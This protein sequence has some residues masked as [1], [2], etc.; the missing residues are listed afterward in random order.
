MRL[1]LVCLAVLVIALSSCGPV[2]YRAA[3]SVV[4][5]VPAYQRFVPPVF[6]EYGHIIGANPNG[7]PVL[8]LWDSGLMQLSALHGVLMCPDQRLGP[9]GYRLVH[10]RFVYSGTWPLALVTGDSL[11]GVLVHAEV[12]ADPMHPEP[13]PDSLG[14]FLGGSF[15]LGVRADTLTGY[16]VAQYV[17]RCACLM[18]VPVQLVRE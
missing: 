5:P 12:A 14:R 18:P 4:L 11:R 16:A 6:D 13:L 9:S 8:G 10:C 15:A 2:K 7:A 17:G 3:G 1:R